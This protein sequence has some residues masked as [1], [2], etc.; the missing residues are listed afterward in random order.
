MTEHS[1]KVSVGLPVYNG[2]KYLRES[3]ESIL[4]QTFT[5]FELVISDNASTDGTE[6]ICQEYAGKDSRVRYYRSENNIGG[7]NNHNRV[8]ELSKGKY[9]HWFSDDDLFAPTFLEKSV[10]VLDHNPS[11]A[12][13]FSMFKVIDEYG[14][15]VRENNQMIGQSLKPYER[16]RELASWEHD[17]EANYGLM[18]ADLLCKTDLERNYPDSDR[19]LLCEVGLYGRFHIIPEVL[20]SRRH[21]PGRSAVIYAGFLPMSWYKP[22][23]EGKEKLYAFFV[24]W[25]QFFHY[26]TIIARA[27]L[28]FKQRLSCYLYMGRWIFMHRR[29]ELMFREAIAPIK[30]VFLR[31]REYRLQPSDLQQKL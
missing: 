26:L 29:L 9:F 3:I 18:R 13:C 10:A 19:T 12:L 25:R 31:L 30:K 24:H 6:M 17:C 11:I 2:E 23:L 14:Q 4:A 5:D 7:S 1:P 28:S 27:P 15:Q 16:L 8:F 21:H 20:F 22:E